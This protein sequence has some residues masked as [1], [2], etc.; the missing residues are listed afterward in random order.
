M[1]LAQMQAELEYLIKDS[2]LNEWL[3][4]WINDAILDVATDYDL[5]PLAL[6]DPYTLAVDTSK[7]LWPLPSTFHKK[8]FLAK[9]VGTDD[10]EHSI[11]RIHKDPTYLKNQDHTLT[12]D[13]VSEIAVIPQG[14]DFYLG[15][16]RLADQDLKLWFYQKP[17]VL[18]DPSDECDCIPFNFVAQVIYPKLIIK[19]YQFIVNMVNDFP[20]TAGPLQYWQGQLALGLNGGRGQGTGLLGYFNINYHPP[21]IGGGKDAMGLRSYCY[22]RF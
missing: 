5:P 1:D 21:R 16:Y 12:A 2:R 20:A 8:V 15:I 14:K 13:S 4:G 19:N 22:G 17:T 9:Y 10:V 6:A 7:W 11:S 18:V 3:V